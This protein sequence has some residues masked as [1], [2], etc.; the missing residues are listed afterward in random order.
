MMEY[1]I[2]PYRTLTVGEGILLPSAEQRYAD[3]KILSLVCYIV[4]AVSSP[5][6]CILPHLIK[7][8]PE[9]IGSVITFAKR[10]LKL[11]MVSKVP[12]KI[13][14]SSRNRIRISLL[15]QIFIHQVPLSVRR[16]KKYSVDLRSQVDGS[17][18]CTS[19]VLRPGAHDVKRPYEKTWSKS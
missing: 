1:R 17:A 11:I 6:Q 18:V 4:S 8:T 13:M 2:L 19:V 15:L 3:P 12:E 16:S 9:L 10:K 7:D 14:Y 5:L